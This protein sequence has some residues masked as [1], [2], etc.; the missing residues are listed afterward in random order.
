MATRGQG[1]EP[2]KRPP[3]FALEEPVRLPPKWLQARRRQP[4]ANEHLSVFAEQAAAAVVGETPR[5]GPHEG[6]S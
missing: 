5:T 2:L 3:D 1:I 6:I 4:A